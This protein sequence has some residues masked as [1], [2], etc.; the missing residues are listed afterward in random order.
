M[1]P[2]TAV[3]VALE[4]LASKVQKVSIDG[5]GYHQAISEERVAK[6][7]ML[8]ALTETIRPAFDSLKVGGVVTIAQ[9][10]QE[11]LGY[12]RTKTGE[13]VFVTW[14][15]D[16]GWSSVHLLPEEVV[17]ARWDIAEIFRNVDEQLDRQLGGMK[18]ERAVEISV[19]ARVLSSLAAAWK[20]GG[21]AGR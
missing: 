1:S 12:I 18:V 5:S 15:R 21:L 13:L 17:A 16:E 2:E 3:R 14:E 19:V 8:E 11:R 10:K 20:S 7:N 6:A 9:R 4:A